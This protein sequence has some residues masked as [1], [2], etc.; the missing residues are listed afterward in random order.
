LDVHAEAKTGRLYPQVTYSIDAVV[1]SEFKQTP[2]V[3]CSIGNAS[4]G[5][6]TLCLYVKIQGKMY[7]L[8]CKHVLLPMDLTA[9]GMHTRINFRRI[10]NLK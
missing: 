9:P 10:A 5:A 6:G 7:G 2:K 1:P 3:G 4:T 8:T